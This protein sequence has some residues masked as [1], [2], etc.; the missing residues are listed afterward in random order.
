MNVLNLEPWVTNSSDPVSG[1]GGIPVNMTTIA[2]KM[3]LG[4]Y[5]TAAVGKWVGE[6]SK[7]RVNA[8]TCH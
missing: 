8:E 1:Y 4:G 5:Y 6:G 2:E 7:C 3:G